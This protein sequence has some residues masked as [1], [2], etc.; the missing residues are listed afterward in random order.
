MAKILESET[1]EEREKK[2]ETK[3]ELNIEELKKKLEEC[4]K[5]K[6]EYLAGWQRER[7]DF[8]NYKKGELER[9]GEIIKY[10]DLGLI[11]KIL[12]IADNFELAE[13]N[14]PENLKTDEN[15]KGILQTKNQILDFLKN[16]GVEEIKSV[17]EKFDP[18]FHE[19]IEEVEVKDKES[20]IVI[21]EIQK[22]YKI[23][24]RLLR[25]AKVKISK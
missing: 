15:V 10:G 2:E 14:L 20:G 9:I 3:K 13:K 24:G 16:Q 22:G 12:P 7:A 8:L 4:Q 25:P 18:N 5:L 21:E 17:G 19:V 11:L 1:M 23:N 6:D